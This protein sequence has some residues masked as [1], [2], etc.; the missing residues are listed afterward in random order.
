MKMNT[1]VLTTKPAVQDALT[2]E[3][4][5]DHQLHLARTRCGNGLAQQRHGGMAV[6]VLGNIISHTKANSGPLAFSRGNSAHGIFHE[7]APGEAHGAA[8]VYCNDSKH[9]TAA[10]IKDA[11]VHCSIERNTIGGKILSNPPTSPALHVRGKGRDIHTA[12]A[13]MQQQLQRQIPISSTSSQQHTSI[14]PI[15]AIW[16]RPIHCCLWLPVPPSCH[17][18]SRATSV[19]SPPMS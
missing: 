18:S 10:R 19:R 5:G 17:S 13:D 14:A 8:S 9:Q 6:R 1:L 7:V 16:L 3:H 12:A 4:Q 15:Q 2:L 11:L